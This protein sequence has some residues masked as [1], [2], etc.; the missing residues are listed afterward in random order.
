MNTWNTKED[1]QII[2]FY[3]NAPREFILN[4]LPGRTWTAIRH[5]ASKL[6]RFRDTS[7]SRFWERV[8]WHEDES[9]CWNWL[10]RLD[11]S[12]Y[13]DFDFWGGT[14]KAHIYSYRVLCGNIPDDHEIDHL[15]RNRSCV[16]PKHLEAVTHAENIARSERAT[17]NY[18]QNG[19]I[20]TSK[21][22]YINKT[23]GQR[24][25]RICLAEYNRAYRVRK[26]QS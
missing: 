9:R 21:N 10:G 1:L 15:C 7:L 3:E 18:C 19:H 6:C 5:R 4:K 16:N 24:V 25:C 17:R 26:K 13:G 12:G 14:N 20:Y 22:L 23:S 2:L 8:D 11:R